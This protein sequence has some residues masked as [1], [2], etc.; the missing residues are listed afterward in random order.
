MRIL[1][2]LA[3]GSLVLAAQTAFAQGAGSVG[4]RAQSY[5][6]FFFPQGAPENYL[7]V[8]VART[9]PGTRQLLT[10]LPGVLY[11]GGGPGGQRP[12]PPSVLRALCEAGFSL[13]VYAYDIG[14]SNPGPI[15]CKNKITG[16]ANTL[17]YIA[18][19]ATDPAFKTQFLSRVRSVAVNPARGP[20]FVHCWNGYHA[21]G[22]L[23]AVALRQVCGWDGGTASAYWRRHSGGFPLIS[24]I[25]KFQPQDSLDV[26]SDVRAQLCQQGE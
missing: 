6:N 17:T 7:D 14:W 8:K 10:V 18:G 3:V 2:L 11:R 9:I 25:N 16:Q 1:K 4:A 19:R 15:A 13:A 5:E 22:E 26:P 20:V 21:S 24:R 12:L 23:A